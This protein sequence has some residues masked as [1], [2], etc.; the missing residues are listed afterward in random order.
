MNPQRSSAWGAVVLFV[1]GGVLAAVHM[2]KLPPAL[3]LMRAELGFGLVAG[4]FVLALFNLLGMT[5]AVFFGGLVERVGRVRLLRAGFAF[6][7]LGGALGALAQGLPVLMLSRLFEGFGFVAISIS[8]PVMVMAAA[9]SRDQDFALGMWSVYTPLGMS[10]VMLA[11]PFLLD[12]LGWRGLWWLVAA[13]CPLMAFAILRQ[14]GRFAPPQMPRRPSMTLAAEALATPGL[15]LIALL[16]CLYAF[17]WVTLMVWLPTFLTESMGFSL[18]RAAL[19]S[20]LVVLVNVPGCLLGGWL[21]RRGSSARHLVATGSAVMGLGALVIFLPLL[22][23]MA[24][25]AACAAF[26]FLGGLVPPSLF[27][28]VPRAAPS[29][30]HISAGNGMLMQGS[31]LGQ[32]TGAPLVA[33]AVTMAGGDWRFAVFPMLMASLGA[34]W[35]A[36]MWLGRPSG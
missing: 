18:Q 28:S 4:G 23:D 6:L 36:L 15:Q 3:P 30:Q 31:A 13:L 33:L 29:A 27:N 19:I 1:L 26:S 8:L 21:M 7:I 24:R 9:A 22:P 10:L 35:A 5:V 16:F 2:G 32:F 14:M 11:A 12:M 34:L 20:A 25:L 17:Q